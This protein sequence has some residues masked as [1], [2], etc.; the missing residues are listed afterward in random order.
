MVFTKKSNMNRMLFAVYFFGVIILLNAT[1]M[2]DDEDNRPLKKPFRNATPMTTDNRENTVGKKP[3]GSSLKKSVSCI[4]GLNNYPQSIFIFQNNIND[5][6]FNLM[7][8]ED[9]STTL[10]IQA[11]NMQMALNAIQTIQNE[12]VDKGYQYLLKATT[13][14][15]LPF[16]GGEEIVETE[17]KTKIQNFVDD[18]VTRV[19]NEPKILIK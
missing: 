4:N 9:E 13:D 14:Y 1:P 12:S 3:S 8:A 19:Q 2:E 16:C 18:F 6:I 15:V 17:V 5:L 11:N 7:K 10:K